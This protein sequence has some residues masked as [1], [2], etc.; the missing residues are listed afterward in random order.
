MV[1]YPVIPPVKEG[2]EFN[3]AVPLV[4]LSAGPEEAKGRTFLLQEEEKGE[5]RMPMH[6]MY[7][8][9]FPPYLVTSLS[10][11]CTKGKR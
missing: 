6:S 2:M 4:K 11:P 9:T 3:N 5:K 10:H 7:C 8:K 1:I